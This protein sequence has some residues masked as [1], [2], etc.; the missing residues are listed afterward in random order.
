MSGVTASGTGIFENN[1]YLDATISGGSAVSLTYLGG[2]L[3]INDVEIESTVN[4]P[5]VFTL[6]GRCLGTE[7]PAT[8]RGV[9]IQNGKKH[10]RM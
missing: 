6:D 7:V 2:A 10:I 4:D 8:F 3:G 9:Y 1:C 5:R